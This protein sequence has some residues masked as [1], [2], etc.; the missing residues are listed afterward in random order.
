MDTMQGC[1]GDNQEV[2]VPQGV[3][4]HP[5]LGTWQC[6][7]CQNPLLG[8]SRDEDNFSSVRSGSPE[9]G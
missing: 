7:G 6:Q 2:W 3:T 1:Y 8:V 9:V 4:E 5:V